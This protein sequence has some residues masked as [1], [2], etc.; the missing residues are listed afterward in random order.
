MQISGIRFL[1]TEH[2][3][4][5]NEYLDFYEEGIH[6]LDEIQLKAV[7]A[8]VWPKEESIPFDVEGVLVGN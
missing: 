6:K 5:K 3:D 2:G 7:Q 4:L 8:G 1:K